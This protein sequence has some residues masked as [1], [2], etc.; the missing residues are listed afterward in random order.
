[1]EGLLFFWI[2]EWNIFDWDRFFRFC[3]ALSRSGLFCWS[4]ISLTVWLTIGSTWRWQEDNIVRYDLCFISFHSCGIIPATCLEIAFDIDLF[5]FV[6]ILFRDISETSPCDTVMIFDFFLEH[7]S[8]IFPFAIGCDR[9]CCDFLT[10]GR[11]A[12]FWF[13]GQVSDDLYFVEWIAHVM[14]G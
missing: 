2:L 8:S 3:L 7:A 1:M 13:C 14:K 6:H 12:N 4:R 5:P 10:I 11:F 9:E